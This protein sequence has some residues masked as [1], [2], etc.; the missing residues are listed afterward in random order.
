MAVAVAAALLLGIVPALEAA[1]RSSDHA[2]LALE[3]PR[4]EHPLPPLLVQGG[5]G[6]I[7]IA[8]R[9]RAAVGA[10]RT[11]A[12]LPRGSRT[13]GATGGSFGTLG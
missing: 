10:P 2:L 7:G 4:L 11:A 5:G 1:V 12:P 9:R 6:G 8:V 13:A 3:L